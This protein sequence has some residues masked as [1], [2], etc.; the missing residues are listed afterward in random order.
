M[1]HLLESRGY[2]GPNKRITN[3]CI[4]F[5][6]SIYL[7]IYFCTAHLFL[8]IDFLFKTQINKT[9]LCRISLVSTEKKTVQHRT[10]PQRI[11]YHDIYFPEVTLIII[12]FPFSVS[13]PRVPLFPATP[14][15]FDTQAPTKTNLESAL[16]MKYRVA[17]LNQTGIFI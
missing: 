12:T 1:Y 5:S 2:K 11:G 13:E 10:P 16:P 15:R 8:T 17:Q 14:P 7:F 6:L 9:K 4:I 3:I